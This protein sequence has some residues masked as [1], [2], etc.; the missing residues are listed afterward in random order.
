M[1]TKFL[2]KGQDMTNKTHTLIIG[3][4]FA[5]ATAAQELSKAGVD[6]TLVDRKDYFEVTYAN[7]RNLVDFDA[8]GSA[9]RK[10]YKDFIQGNFIQAGITKLN[11]KRALLDNGEEI[12][13]SR[14]I[15]ATGSRYNAFPLAK[16]VNALSI[17]ER[18]D[19]LRAS[20]NSLSKAKSV[21]IIGAGA[22]G[23]ELAGE[24]A[25]THPQIK[26]T[27]AEAGNTVLGVYSEKAKRK[28]T[29]Q[30]ENLGVVIKPNR[31]FEQVGDHFLDKK[32]GETIT[33]DIVY[34]A[35]GV[36]PNSEFL[37]AELANVLTPNG[38]VK[39]DDFYKVAQTDN[40]YAVGDV[41]DLPDLK[42][43]AFATPQAKNLV[44]NLIAEQ[45]G[46]ALKAHKKA[47]MMGLIPVGPNKGV[48]QL[49]F[50]T[51]T[52]KFLIDI[53]NKDMFIGKT[54]GSLSAQ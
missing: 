52:W 39:V 43:G 26:V 3:G 10:L 24:I 40:L 4:G 49:P 32:S 1:T 46:K 12:E 31:I 34:T 9:P 45:K 11:T 42:M 44:A 17:N 16:S 18:N 28:A 54:F 51:T 8:L 5:G 47:P 29:E 2:R 48:A 33:A 38:F 25:H 19:E 6:V 21:L 36:R 14:A 20:A 37:Q 50:A 27:L 35:V 23:V 22:V 7:L 13:F 30:L 53:K 15:I 41:A